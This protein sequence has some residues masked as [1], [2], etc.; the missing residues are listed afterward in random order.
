MSSP[1]VERPDPPPTPSQSQSRQQDTPPPASSPRH[2]AEASIGDLIGDIGNDL[3]RLLRNE[4]ELAKAELKEE[5]RKAGKV[6]GLY[7]GAGYA[8]GLALL[9]GSLAAV[10]GLRHV[11][12]LAWA[13]LILAA[14]WAVVGAAAYAAGRR[15]MRSVQLTPERSLESLK[16]DATWARHPTG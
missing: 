8:A 14:V 9:L 3:S 10:Y 5:G 16:E 13:A 7:G 15:R 11:I 1:H 12:D 2:G 6:A 4:V